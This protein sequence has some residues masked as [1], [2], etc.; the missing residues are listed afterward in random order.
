MIHGAAYLTPNWVA[1]HG[2]LRGSLGCSA[3]RPE[4]ARM[5]V[6]HIKIVQFLFAWHNDQC[7]QQHSAAINCKP[8]QLASVR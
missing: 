4:V 2:R 3:V 7:W 8:Q 5:V 1:K 6:D